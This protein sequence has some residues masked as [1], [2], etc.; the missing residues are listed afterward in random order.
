MPGSDAAGKIEERR[1]SK[2]TVGQSGLDV[3]TGMGVESK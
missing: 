2:A 1:P 3:W